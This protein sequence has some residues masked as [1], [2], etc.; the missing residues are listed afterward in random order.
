MRMVPFKAFSIRV[1]GF[2]QFK[3]MVFVNVKDS[4]ELT[5]CVKMLRLAL[6]ENHIDFDRKNF[7]PHTTLVR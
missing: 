7:L 1:S 3:D 2:R 5:D 4:S 6:S